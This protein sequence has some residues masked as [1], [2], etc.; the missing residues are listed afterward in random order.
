MVLNQ[1]RQEAVLD[2][3]VRK[4]LPFQSLGVAKTT[5]NYNQEEILEELESE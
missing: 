5:N 3:I 2:R 1:R 4:R